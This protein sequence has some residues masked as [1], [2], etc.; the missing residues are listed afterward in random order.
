MGES[1]SLSWDSFAL[2][3]LALTLT[4]TLGALRAAEAWNADSTSMCNPIL[5]W[6]GTCIS[7]SVGAGCPVPVPSDSV[8]PE[9]PRDAL[10]GMVRTA[11]LAI[12]LAVAGPSVERLELGLWAMGS[13]C[14]VTTGW[15]VGGMIRGL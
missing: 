14:V 2:L 8:G 13:V 12:S 3:A 5:V 7:D 11:T 9:E 6:D 1:I 10:V 15:W 4:P